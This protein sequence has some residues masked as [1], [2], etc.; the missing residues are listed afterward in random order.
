MRINTNKWFSGIT[1]I[2]MVTTIVISGVMVIG[3]ALGFR[4]LTYHYQQDAVLRDLRTYGN[5]V[6]RETIKEISLARFIDMDTQGG[7]A[8]IKLARFDTYGNQINT[9]I[10]A[11]ASAGILINYDYPLN[12]TLELPKK[13]RFRNNN[14]RHISLHSFIATEEPVISSN[15]QNF[16]QSTWEIIMGLAIETTVAPGGRQLEIMEFKRRVFM[17]NKYISLTSQ[18]EGKGPRL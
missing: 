13:G 6:M 10:T 9:T 14:Q 7:F 11:N 17:P 18:M 5:T 8:R 15:Q 16:A 3:L 1:M 12:G 2:E 4:T